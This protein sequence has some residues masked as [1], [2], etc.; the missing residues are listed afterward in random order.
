MF[1][2]GHETGTAALNAKLLQ[3][4]TYMIEVVLFEVFLDL[5]KSYNVLEQERCLVIITVYG[6]GPRTIRI[7][8]T[9]WDHLTILAR[10]GINFERPCK[11]YCGVTQGYPLLPNIFIEVVDAVIRHWMAVVAPAKDVTEVLGLSIQDL[12]AYFYANDGLV[13]STHT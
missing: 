1:Q 13:T 5:Q 7:I 2:E 12:A 9:N 11:G 10:A 6:V 4:L 8:W 3:H